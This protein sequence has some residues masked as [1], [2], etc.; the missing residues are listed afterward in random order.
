[1]AIIDKYFLSPKQTEY[2]DYHMNAHS[3]PVWKVRTPTVIPGDYFRFHK[4]GR[5]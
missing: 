2:I 1:M 4:N 5:S 3:L